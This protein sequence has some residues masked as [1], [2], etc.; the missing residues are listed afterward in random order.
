[1]PHTCTSSLSHTHTHARTHTYAQSENSDN[2]NQSTKIHRNACRLE[3]SD[4]LV[5]WP[6]RTKILFRFKFRSQGHKIMFYCRCSST[7]CG[8][9]DFIP[10]TCY[11]QISPIR[12]YTRCYAHTPTSV[13][14][15]PQKL[16]HHQVFFRFCFFMPTKTLRWRRG[17]SARVC[18]AYVSLSSSKYGPVWLQET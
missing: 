11:E 5:Q 13:T 18:R 6:K 10:W 12:N 17:G 8:T 14:L 3:Y 16:I 1:M 9:Y 7:Q 4:S 15:L 2:A